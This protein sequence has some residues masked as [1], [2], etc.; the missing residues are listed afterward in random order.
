MGNK[1]RISG[2]GCALVDYLFKP[3]DF[4]GYGFKKYLSQRPG[5]G[6]LS[7]GKLVFSGE[8][9]KFAGTGYPEIRQEITGGM[10]PVALN[11]G[12]P[13]IVSL[14]HASQLLHG[15]ET[16][17]H[18]YGCRGDDKSGLFI[19]EILASTPIDTTGYSTVKGFTPFTDVFSD[20]AWDHGHG[21]RAFVNNIGVAWKF[22]PEEL[23]E[24]FFKS[25]ITVFG[26][27]ALVPN[28]HRGL[29]QLLK[30][31]R[32]NGSITVVNTV[33][34]FLSEK[35]DPGK[36]W[37]LG[38]S[39][40]ALQYTD[41]L[42]A[43]REEALKHSG[44]ETIDEAL[45]FFRQSGTGAAVITHGPHP[46]HFYSEGSLFGKVPRSRLPASEHVIG[47]L[48][49][50]PALAGDTTGCGD[51][52]TGGML[53][54]VAMQ[55]IRNPGKPADMISAVSLGVVSGGF[56]CFLHGGTFHEKFPGQKSQMMDKYYR[57][58]IEQTGS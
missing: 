41:L 44:C 4:S 57:A 22:L 27:T 16:T 49:D 20:P 53:A 21:E 37:S 23:D 17:V 31:A 25:D 34:D 19:K 38:D 45:S 32:G 7:P 48:R 36:P 11:I 24:N 3:V 6:G 58:Y 9:E 39:N 43:D 35:D 30:R 1:F 29:G 46:V 18:Y 2:T 28:I 56:A 10:E 26:G 47:E 52:F 40:R 54:S 12:G 15:Q 14:I 42:I 51:N 33:Y 55:K 13:S 50:N 8:L 5:D